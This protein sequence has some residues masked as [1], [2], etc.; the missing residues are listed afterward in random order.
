MREGGK[1]IS[2]IRASGDQPDRS[3]N[4]FCWV[5][6]YLAQSAMVKALISLNCRRSASEFVSAG[7]DE[8]SNS[9]SDS[10]A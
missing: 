10:P 2:R 1:L 9:E 3:P 6:Q 5:Q 8:S 4:V 7:L